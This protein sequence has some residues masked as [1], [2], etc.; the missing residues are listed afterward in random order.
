MRQLTYCL[1]LLFLISC[2]DSGN[3]NGSA[4][5]TTPSIDIESASSD[6]NTMVGQLWNEGYP[7]QDTALVS[8]LFHP[9]FVFVD[10]EGVIISRDEELA[11]VSNY[12]NQ[13]ANFSFE[14]SK[15][16]IDNS[17]TGVVFAKCRFLGT[18]GE[19][20]FAT[21]FLQALTFVKKESTWQ[22]LYS[23]V[24]GV[25]EERFANAPN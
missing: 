1:V 22:I 10:D 15:T 17:G 20:A 7:N 12:G 19:G 5:E 13:Y 2:S 16:I 3:Q 25:K 4:T 21:N 24:S 6:L 14:I 11:Y 8:S 18:D 23:H 9:S